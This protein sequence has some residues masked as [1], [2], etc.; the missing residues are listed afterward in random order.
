MGVES[1]E[2]IA[3]HSIVVKNATLA[4]RKYKKTTSGSNVETHTLQM[5][6]LSKNIPLIYTLS[7]SNSE[8]DTI[9]G[10]L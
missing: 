10:R 7:G 8:K 1:T 9:N 5:G 4:G 6:V 2:G 3:L